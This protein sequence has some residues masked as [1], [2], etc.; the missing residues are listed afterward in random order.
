M[1]KRVEKIQFHSK[2][3]GELCHKSKNLYN[4]A[5]Y[6]VRQ[7]LFNEGKWIRYN[8]LYKL[9]KDSEPYRAFPAKSAQ[10]TLKMLDRNWKSFFEA[11]KAFKKTPEL[12]TGMPRPPG[13]KD[14]DGEAIL[15]FTNQQVKIKDGMIKFPKIVPLSIRTRLPESTNLREVRIIPKHAGYTC[16]IVFEKEIN[17]PVTPNTGRVLGIDPGSTNLITIANNFGENPIIVK[18][19][20]VKSINQFYNKSMAKL[21]KTYKKQGVENGKS[22]EILRKK[23]D[24]RISDILHK[25]SRQVVDYAKEMDVGRIIIGHNPLWKQNI[26]IGK[27]NNQNHAQIPHNV[28]S[29]M[30]EY[31]AEEYG[32]TV[33]LVEESYTSKCSFLDNEPMEHQEKYAGRRVKRGLFRSAE[34]TLLNADVNGALNIIKKGIPNAFADGIEGVVLHPIRVNPL[35]KGKLVS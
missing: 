30:I 22:A 15:I 32:I 10:Q 25:T 2:E 8:E 11:M 28:L 6:I 19:G 24:S 5:N 23:R 12:F 3:I 4:F 7:E 9:V 17:D 1:V 13:F 18:G 27:R 16:E 21:Q 31:K 33:E 26:N 29:S 14:K 35:I 20:A 34:G